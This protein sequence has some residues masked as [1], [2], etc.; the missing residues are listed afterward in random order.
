MATIWNIA[1]QYNDTKKLSSKM[2]FDVGE[3]FT[4]K[5]LSSQEDDKVLVRLS[6]GW[7][8]EADIEGESPVNQNVAIRFQVEG[9]ENGKIKLKILNDQQYSNEDNIEV[10]VSEN[11]SSSDTELSKLMTKYN[12][13]LTKEN[14]VFVKSIIDFKEKIAGNEEEKNNFINNFLA[15]I[16]ETEDSS[17]GQ[18][19]KN[20][21][22]EFLSSYET[23]D[24]EDI[25]FFLENDIDITKEN[26]DSYNN[27]FKGDK[28]IDELFKEINS[29]MEELNIN[30]I[31]G[32]LDSE[33]PVEK[34][35]KDI[36]KQ[37]FN[38]AMYKNILQKLDVTDNKDMDS[39]AIL[40]FIDNADDESL[41]QVIN[42]TISELFGKEVQLSDKGI[43]YLKSVLSDINSENASIVDLNESVFIDELAKEINNETKADVL[44]NQNNETVKEESTVKNLGSE[45]QIEKELQGISKEDFNKSIYK[46]IL[47]KLDVTDSKEVNSNV[48]SRFINNAN[49]ESLKE[50]IN[51][52]VSELLGKEVQLSDKQITHLKNILSDINSKS[53]NMTE[54]NESIF[55]NDQDSIFEKL[56]NIDKDE[57]AKFLKQN[58][59]TANNPLKEDIKSKLD[60]I[61]KVVENMLKATNLDSKDAEKISQLIK[62]YSTEFKLINSIS[63]EYYY[64]DVPISRNDVEYPCKLIIKDN[65]KEG[66]RIDKTNV[67]IV[68]SI[69]T[70][71]LGVVDGYINISDGKIKVDLKCNKESMNIL[72]KGKE[73]LQNALKS[74][75]LDTSIVVSQKEEE[76][77]FTTCR[78]FFDEEHIGKINAMV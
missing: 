3:K 49:D 34:G 5:I 56:K 52:S 20:M 58:E 69:K 45:N 19:I 14:M 78:S 71:H 25:L 59:S 43:S 73:K 26:I 8:F 66:K 9:F 76:V 41:K 17:R 77:T 13:Q 39:N 21:L 32:D 29:T 18:E 64:L 23:I 67:K 48:I 68:L 1:N 51:K 40:R 24:K 75:N 31:V 38:K 47:Q 37:D 36:S 12:M 72:D 50:V 4:G 28:T 46:N 60:D 54:L 11:T 53:L 42:K 33:S 63:N 44:T 15:S 57:I 74:L 30:D 35:F 6:N 10:V 62:K 61:K 16:G 65:R 22:S 27:L 2:T 55:I 70:V 7:Q